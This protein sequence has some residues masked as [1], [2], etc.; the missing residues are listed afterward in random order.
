M[1]FIIF[2]LTFVMSLDRT[3]MSVSAPIIQKT[4]HFNLVE[5]SLIL[6]SFSWTYAFFQ[7]PGGIA[8]ERKGSRLTLTIADL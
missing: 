8:A 3:N 1:A 4:F 6:T 2:P 5:M 7:V